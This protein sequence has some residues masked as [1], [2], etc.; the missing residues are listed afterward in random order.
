MPRWT[1]SCT[2]APKCRHECRVA[3]PSSPRL[4]VPQRPPAPPAT[5]ASGAVPRC[6]ALQGRGPPHGDPPPHTRPLASFTG[7]LWLKRQFCCVH[8]LRWKRKQMG[9]KV[10]PSCTCRA[11]LFGMRSEAFPDPFLPFW[12]FPAPLAPRGLRGR[13]PAPWAPW[14]GVEAGAGGGAGRRGSAWGL[15]GARGRGPIQ[16]FMSLRWSVISCRA[17]LSFH[18]RSTSLKISVQRCRSAAWNS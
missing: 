7:H 15:G 4:R 8:R 3:G 6:G 13:V 16:L 2:G 5:A 10:P 9:F 18:L 14:A 11:Q 17:S 1:R 12:P